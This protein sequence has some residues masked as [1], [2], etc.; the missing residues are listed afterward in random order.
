MRLLGDIAMPDSLTAS[1]TPRGIV[2]LLGNPFTLLGARIMVTAPF[3][4]GGLTKLLDW[5]AGVAEMEHV[6][7]H[8]AVLFNAAA[9]CTQLLGSALI[10][11]NRWV[12]LGAGALGVFTVWAT[13]LAHRFWDFSGPERFAQMNSFFEHWTIVASF[14][15][16][17]VLSFRK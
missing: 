1:D 13:Y 14:I 10:I 3:I 16:V 4:V 8:P 12:W 5:Q 15:L 11:V 6:G 9:L 7:L 2:Q 17:S